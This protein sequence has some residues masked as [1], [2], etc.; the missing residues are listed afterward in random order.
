LEATPI[1]VPSV[2]NISTNR[3][4]NMT[5]RKSTDK[6]FEKSSLNKVGA[7]LGTPKPLD[8]SGNTLYMPSSGFG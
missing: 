4:A 7:I 6:I 1:K 2:S 5:T 3:N 8:K